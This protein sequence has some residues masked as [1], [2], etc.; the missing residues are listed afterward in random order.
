MENCKV[1]AITNQKGGVGN[2][3]L[4]I[5]KSPSLELLSYRHK[6]S[7]G[8]PIIHNHLPRFLSQANK[9]VSFCQ[10]VSSVSG[11][12]LG[13]AIISASRLKRSSARA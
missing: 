5:M 12:G 4:N 3:K 9:S 1:I 13:Y 10:A 2:G 7:E 8:L 11:E 6:T